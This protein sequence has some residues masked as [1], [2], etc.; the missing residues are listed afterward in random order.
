[1]SCVQTILTAVLLIQWS[2]TPLPSFFRALE[3]EL[4]LPTTRVHRVISISRIDSPLALA[5]LA[6]VA[7]AVAIVLTMALGAWISHAIFVFFFGAVAVVAMFGGFWPGAFVAVIGWAI[8]DY[9]F[10]PP[11]V[12]FNFS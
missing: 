12:H 6:A 10:L 4:A 5:R 1:S 11:T 3:S 2:L 8:A 9:F 7:L